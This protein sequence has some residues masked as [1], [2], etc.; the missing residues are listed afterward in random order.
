MLM[1]DNIP[2]RMRKAMLVFGFLEDCLNQLISSDHIVFIWV[3][4]KF[5]EECKDYMKRLGYEYHQY[6][7]WYRPK[8]NRGSSKKVFEYL[9]IY[10]K[11]KLPLRQITFPD[12]LKS[13]FTAGVK[14]RKRKPADAYALI[15]S[16][17][18]NRSK[19]QIWGYTR[20]PSWNVI[21]HNN[22]K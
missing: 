12:P 10:Y 19:L 15:E 8:W 22:H 20:R 21:H 7:I 18:P 6:L 16:L 5:T 9:M 4:E 2:P 14:N 3:T 11:G 13:P 1:V 17:F